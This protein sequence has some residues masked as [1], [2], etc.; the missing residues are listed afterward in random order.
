M[1]ETVPEY[2]GPKLKGAVDWSN[3]WAAEH[4]IGTIDE[5]TGDL[6][7]PVNNAI[8]YWN[9]NPILTI[10]VKKRDG[11]GFRNA[12][13]L[14]GNVLGVPVKAGEG[15]K[16]VVF[17]LDTLKGG[18]KTVSGAMGWW[19]GL[20]AVPGSYFEKAITGRNIDPYFYMRKAN[21]L[22][23]EGLEQLGIKDEVDALEQTVIGA[24]QLSMGG[25][26]MLVGGPVSDYYYDR[27]LGLAKSGFSRIKLGKGLSGEEL[28]SWYKDQSL[29][30]Q[31]DAGK[32]AALTVAA[33]GYSK[34]IAVSFGLW[35]SAGVAIEETKALYNGYELTDEGR[36]NAFVSYGK[37]GAI[38]SLGVHGIGQLVNST[39]IAGMIGLTANSSAKARFVAGLTGS[40]VSGGVINTLLGGGR[41]Y[42]GGEEWTPLEDFGTGM[43]VGIGLYLTRRGAAK[44]LAKKAPGLSD[45]LKFEGKLTPGTGKVLS[46]ADRTLRYMVA[47]NVNYGLLGVTTDRIETG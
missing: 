30:D 24:V 12:A 38:F 21:E 17:N 29:G 45:A 25:L 1:L 37:D 3:Q 2:W 5:N 9:E 40:G 42:L 46:E 32:T 39:R 47:R 41:S 14:D 23:N 33:P 35:G 26:D 43:G 20:A 15:I 34:L 4:G 19:G 22:Q 8:N 27:G 11:S 31:L 28:D 10:S 44:F 13:I 36:K 18:T 16:N 6:I 7:G